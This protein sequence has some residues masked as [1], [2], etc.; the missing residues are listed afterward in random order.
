MSDFWPGP[1][2]VGPDC[3]KEEAAALWTRLVHGNIWPNLEQADKPEIAQTF[4]QRFMGLPHSCCKRAVERVIDEER[5]F[6]PWAVVRETVE[7][8]W[9]SAA[10]L[11]RVK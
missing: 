9:R 10:N 3:T 7:A 1:E 4:I 11:R 8:E 2:I 6:P 5:F